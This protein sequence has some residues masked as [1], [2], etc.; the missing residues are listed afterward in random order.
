MGSIE[1]LPLST[2]W[3]GGPRFNYH[4]GL[5]YNGAA[6]FFIAIGLDLAMPWAILASA[7]AAPDLASPS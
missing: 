3:G 7:L 1:R 6:Q 5:L 4:E 2:L